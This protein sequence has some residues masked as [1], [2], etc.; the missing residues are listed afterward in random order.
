MHALDHNLA[1]IAG[2]FGL[3]AIYAFGSRAGELAALPS[4]AG[5]ATGPSDADIGV[6][7]LA[8]RRLAAR[9]RVRLTAELEEL[10]RVPRVDLVVLPE[11]APFLALEVIRGELLY[12]GDPDAQAEQELYSLRRAGDLA[13]Y[14]RER[15]ELILGPAR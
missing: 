14:E 2:R 8:G 1:D 11:A 13:P 7:P 5:S 3:S 12:C 9:D 15:R 4:G 10:L 6:Q